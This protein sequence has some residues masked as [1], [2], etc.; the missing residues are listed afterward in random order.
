MIPPIKC[1]GKPLGLSPH[2]SAALDNKQD[3][4][5]EKRQVVN[6]LDGELRRIAGDRPGHA[7]I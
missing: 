7:A 4:L 6:L 2:Q 1:G 3:M 5:K